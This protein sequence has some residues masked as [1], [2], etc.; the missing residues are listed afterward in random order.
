MLFFEFPGWPIKVFARRKYG[1]RIWGNF[2]LKMTWKEMKG[3][4]EGN[5]R[6]WKEGHDRNWENM[7]GHASRR[8][9]WNGKATATSKNY[10][11]K[12]GRFYISPPGSFPIT[13]LGSCGPRC[14][15]HSRLDLNASSIYGV[16][17]MKYSFWISGISQLKMTWKEF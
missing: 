9:E 3:E 14:P 10:R 2:R 15:V 7:N 16:A 12:A 1:F 8:I 5:G 13:F 4:W 6:T 17:W 11:S